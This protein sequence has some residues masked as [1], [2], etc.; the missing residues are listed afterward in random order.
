M[1]REGKIIF[2]DER[3]S[4]IRD[5]KKYQIVV[6]TFLFHKVMLLPKQSNFEV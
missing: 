2:K 3:L 1:L 4:F 5:Y 6:E